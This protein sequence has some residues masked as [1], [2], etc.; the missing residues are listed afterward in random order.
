[1]QRLLFTV[2]ETAEMLSLSRNRVYE[3]IYAERLAS[4]KIGRS[5]RISLASIHRLIEEESANHAA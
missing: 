1:M 5:R 4:V 2:R 3:L